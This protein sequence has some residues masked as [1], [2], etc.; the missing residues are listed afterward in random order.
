MMAKTE[1]KEIAYR[2]VEIFFD[3]FFDVGESHSGISSPP[4]GPDNLLL[5]QGADE[6]ILCPFPTSLQPRVSLPP[7]PPT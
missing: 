7:L 5:E 1:V 6:L 2:S 3:C 4:G